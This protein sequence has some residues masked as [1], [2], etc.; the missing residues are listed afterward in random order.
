[1]QFIESNIYE[2][3]NMEE[4]AEAAYAQP[5]F[6][7]KRNDFKKRVENL[8]CYVSIYGSNFLIGGKVF[9]DIKACVTEKVDPWA[10]L[11]HI[12]EITDFGKMK[13]ELAKA[14]KLNVG[15]TKKLERIIK[16][17]KNFTEIAQ[18][19][20]N[21]SESLRVDNF[22]LIDW[23]N[24]CAVKSCHYKFNNLIVQF[25]HEIGE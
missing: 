2:N 15:L 4:H 25:N 8:R 12:L 23:E 9:K 13:D 22:S 6:A 19:L 16:K 21:R 24:Q 18:N 1:M 20:K 7:G 3:M 5:I 17:G 10:V 14:S 11:K